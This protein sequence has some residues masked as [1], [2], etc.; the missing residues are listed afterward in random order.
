MKKFY[1]SVVFLVLLPILVFPQLQLKT[2]FSNESSIMFQNKLDSDA[3]LKLPANISGPSDA[4]GFYKGMM[5]VGLMADLSLPFGDEDTGFRHIAGL[6]YS[7]HAMFGYAVAK[8][9]LLSF[10]VGFVSFG[11]QTDEGSEFGY[12]YVYED[13]YTQI[14]ILLGGYYVFETGSGFVPFIGAAL[15]VYLQ[16]YKVNWKETDI[17]TGQEFYSLDE[18]F[19]K[20]AFGIAPGAGAYLMLSGLMLN[21]IIEYNVLLSKLPEPEYTYNYTVSKTNG[22]FSVN[23]EAEEPNNDEKANSL[24]FS[25]GVSF[26]LGQ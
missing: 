1:F 12:N 25:L 20:T 14:P 16:N 24:S 11:T 18:S 5:L 6:G 10:R 22:T 19:S 17:N 7:A 9:F 23:Q 3:E 8:S 15:G 13:T 26:P 4:I 2:N 21:F